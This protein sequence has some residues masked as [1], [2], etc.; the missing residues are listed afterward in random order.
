MA[1]EEVGSIW[2]NDLSKTIYS[3][4]KNMI[5]MCSPYWKVQ[6]TIKDLRSLSF[7]FYLWMENRKNGFHAVCLN[8]SNNFSLAP[9]L[10]PT[11]FY[12]FVLRLNKGQYFT[13]VSIQAW[14]SW[15]AV[16]SCFY[17]QIS[18]SWLNLT[19]YE[20]H[21]LCNYMKFVDRLLDVKCLFLRRRLKRHKASIHFTV[22]CGI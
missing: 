6:T 20:P 22:W 11:K 13:Q 15:T 9:V 12:R 19:S 17:L 8:I 7:F 14:C 5:L 18:T 1:N 16:L 2:P 21:Y 4:L 3:I 10:S